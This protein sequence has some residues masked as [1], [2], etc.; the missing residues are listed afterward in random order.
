MSPLPLRTPLTLLLLCVSLLLSISHIAAQ[1]LP[2]TGALRV[3]K[4]IVGENYP[5]DS[6]F[7][8]C[9]S[10]GGIGATPDCQTVIGDGGMAEWVE[11]A[12][13]DDYVVSENDAGPDW[14][15][16]GDQAGISVAAGA[17]TE[18]TLTN[19]YNP[20]PATGSLRVTKAITGT[21]YPANPQ[22]TLCVSG[23]SIGQTPDCQTVRGD[24]DTAEWLDLA[25]AADYVISERDAGAKWDEPADQTGVQVVAGQTTEIVVTNRYV[26]NSV[27]VFVV[28]GQSNAG[29][30]G[31]SRL[32]APER[33]RVA[34]AWY[35]TKVT[36]RTYRLSVMEPFL[37]R[38]AKFGITKMA[39]AVDH[40]I[41]YRLHQMCPATPMV[42]V[43]VT[44][45]GTSI[46]AWDPNFNTPAW[47]AAMR[48]VGNGAY[49]PM[50]P[51]VLAAAGGTL[52]AVQAA[53]D[54]AGLSPEMAGV[55]YIQTERDSKMLAGAQQYEQ[56]L[57]DLIAAFRRDWGEDDLPVL[58][59]DSHTA[60]NAY[61]GLVRQAAANVAELQPEGITDDPGATATPGTAMVATRDLP[62][63]KDGV[64]FNSE[65]INLFGA[66]LAERWLELNGGC[67]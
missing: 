28:T 35:S 64:H 61:A 46:V 39:Y 19:L 6:Q 15:E 13:A 33:W 14:T 16:P 12:P 63:Y 43:R 36:S 37:F 34:N 58:F 49:A 48:A 22:F 38:K 23:G 32:L 41:A 11:L 56:R 8:I 55:F 26:S 5:A 53:P 52:A 44:S 7:T 2:V 10:G 21:G 67:E 25:P 51:Q 47:K 30:N 65:G 60:L 45:G 54:L 18:V 42:F 31:N 57:R 24:G 20:S 9:L 50:Y 3:T 66:R 27:L 1:D 59:M 4:T 62:K 17:T 40:A 29:P